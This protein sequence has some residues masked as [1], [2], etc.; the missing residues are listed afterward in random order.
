MKSVEFVYVKGL[1]DVVVRKEVEVSVVELVI[2]V[3]KVAELVPVNSMVAVKRLIVVLV[4]KR[5]A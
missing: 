3:E 5:C 4:V 2:F 1:T